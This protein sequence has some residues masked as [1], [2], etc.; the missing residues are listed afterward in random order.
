MTTLTPS[1]ETYGL[2]IAA[3]V[4]IVVILL[5]LAAMRMRKEEGKLKE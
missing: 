4:A 5:V 1:L 2:Y 3:L